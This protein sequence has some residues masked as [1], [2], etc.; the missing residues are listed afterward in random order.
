MLVDSSSVGLVSKVCILLNVIYLSRILCGRCIKFFPYVLT[1]V[2]VQISDYWMSASNLSAFSPNFSLKCSTF[3][4]DKT[5]APLFECPN[6]IPLRPPEKNLKFQIRNVSSGFSHF[7]TSF[8][9]N[10]VRSSFCYFFIP[11]WCTHPIVVLSQVVR[12]SASPLCDNFVFSP[13]GVCTKIVG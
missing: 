5:L 10:I 9:F 6:S 2:F 3:D 7:S 11:A 4:I 13:Q 8:N 1:N 12:S